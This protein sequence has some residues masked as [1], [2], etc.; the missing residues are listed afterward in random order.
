MVT[1]MWRTERT[2]MAM[3]H[4]EKPLLDKLG[5]RSGMRVSVL[6]QHERWFL[7]KLRERRADVSA[8][9]RRD[10]DLIFLRCETQPSLGRI[11]S[12]EPSLARNGAVWVL[13]RRGSK[14]ANQNDAIRAGVV[15]GLVDNKSA[16]FSEEWS[17]LRLVIPLARR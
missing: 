10:S 12:I 15:V 9:R 5:V 8:R 3:V 16:A 17:A 11:G 14:E 13:T 2:L 1:S 6:G 7:D 4:A